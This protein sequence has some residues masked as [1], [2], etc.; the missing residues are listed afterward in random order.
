MK[1]TS[2]LA[3]ATKDP[4]TTRTRALQLAD[5]LTRLATGADGRALSSLDAEIVDHLWTAWM[6]TRGKQARRYLM[7][8]ILVQKRALKDKR[9]ATELAHRLEAGELRA[10]MPGLPA[11]KGAQAQVKAAVARIAKLEPRHR[12]RPRKGEPKPKFYAE[13]RRA[14]PSLGIQQV[15][16]RQLIRDYLGAVADEGGRR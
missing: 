6:A 12:G 2:S 10:H 11:G 9:A 13:V 15:T 8:L 4:A 16:E 1:R 5:S 14:L 3:R 7:R